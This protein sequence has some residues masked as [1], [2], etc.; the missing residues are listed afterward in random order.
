M[1]SPDTQLLPRVMNRRLRTHAKGIRHWHIYK[2]KNP[3]VVVNS[4]EQFFFPQK[5]VVG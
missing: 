4:F 2:A 5:E 3:L 1:C